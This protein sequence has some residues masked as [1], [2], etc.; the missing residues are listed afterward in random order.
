[1]A[2][3]HGP[4]KTFSAAAAT[5][6]S[7]AANVGLVV[8][9]DGNGDIVLS[10]HPGTDAIG[11]L[12]DGGRAAGDAC[13]VAMTGRVTRGQAGAVFNEGD[14]LTAAADAQLEPVA[15]AADIVCAVALQ[16]ATVA[17]DLVDVMVA[18]FQQ[19]H[20]GNP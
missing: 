20:D 14:R 11:I 6:L 2:T 16:A 13:L 19:N 12:E 8:A 5:N 15:S 9:L 7:A 3:F 18:G 10:G 17:G 1:M 4:S